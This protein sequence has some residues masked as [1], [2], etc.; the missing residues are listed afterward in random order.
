MGSDRLFC[1]N[2]INKFGSFKNPLATINTLPKLRLRHSLILLVQ[3]ARSLMVSDLR[4][5]TKGSRLEPDC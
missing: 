3:R 1:L 2:S 4:S 5:E